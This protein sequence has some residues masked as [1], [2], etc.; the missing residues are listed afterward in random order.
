[1]IS[2]QAPANEDV[3]QL[4]A[5]LRRIEAEPLDVVMARER[6]TFDELAAP[7][8]EKIVLFGAGSL[9][10]DVLAGLRKAGVEPLAFADNRIGADRRKL[11]EQKQEGDRRKKRDRRRR[12]KAFFGADASSAYP[13][14]DPASRIGSNNA[15][16]PQ[17]MGLPVISAA[18]A[19]ER[20][21]QSACFV[22]SIYQGSA[23][24]RQL[25]A[26]GVR[27]VVPYA[28]LLWKYADVFIPQSGLDLPHHL[29]AQFGAIR[30]CYGRLGDE[31]SR[32]DLREQLLW[33]CWLDFAV[34]STPLAASDIYFPMDLLSPL[35]DEVFVDC[36]SFDGDSIRSFNRH[37][38]GEFRHAFAFE[39]DPVNCTA[40]ASNMEAM[41]IGDRVTVMPY[42]VG[43]MN[44]EVSFACNSSMGSHVTT[45]AGSTIE[46]RRL[47]DIEWPLRPTYIKMDVEGAEVDALAGASALLRRQQPVLAICT[48]HR[49]NH[50][51]QIPNLI[52]S[53]VPEYNLFARRYGEECWEGVCYAIPSRR[54]K[55]A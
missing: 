6:S 46:C 33:R 51:W 36:G 4:E 27:R 19:V 18:E 28:P 16:Q 17:V 52:H 50:L 41:Y 53:I 24:R 49:S 39:P 44:G 42:A 45:D 2:G 31:L 26:L 13:V 20:F 48:Y 38:E 29:R 30:E 47:D 54:L 11:E 12:E 21:G 55:R 37:W 9:G 10:K 3:K 34:L 15:S 14:V 22:V 32:R 5:I 8:G 40:L 35:P 23:V 1:M 25:A 43:N 7:L